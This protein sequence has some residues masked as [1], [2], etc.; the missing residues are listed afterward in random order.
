MKLNI[1]LNTIWKYLCVLWWCTLWRILG[2]H[3]QIIPSFTFYYFSCVFVTCYR[4]TP[5]DTRSIYD[6]NNA[7]WPGE[8]EG[9][10]SYINYAYK[11]IKTCYDNTS[12]RKLPFP[13]IPILG[14]NDRAGYY[15]TL[16]QLMYLPTVLSLSILLLFLLIL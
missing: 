16:V 14:I 6:N 10:L 11:N 8:N 12:W 4:M 3:L 5:N 9:F 13:D 15:A 7:Y 1:F 2:V